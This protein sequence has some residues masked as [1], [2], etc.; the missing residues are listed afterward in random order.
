[1][2][3]DETVSSVWMRA[4]SRTVSWPKEGRWLAKWCQ[5]S[6]IM[7]YLR[8]W[9]IL[10]YSLLQSRTT[11]FRFLQPVPFF[12][13]SLNGGRR[14]IMVG[15]STNCNHFPDHNTKRPARHNLVFFVAIQTY[16]SLFLVAASPFKTSKEV[17]FIIS[18]SFGNLNFVFVNGPR[19]FCLP[20]SAGFFLCGTEI[21]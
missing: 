1:M 15:Y 20:D 7:S 14:K 12:K 5:L 11:S 6:L 3:F 17:H 18:S 16:T 9:N 19:K 2:K 21:W 13:D 4:F 8:G 10:F